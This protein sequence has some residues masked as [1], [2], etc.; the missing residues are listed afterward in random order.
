MAEWQSIESAPKD[1]TRFLA[2]VPGDDLDLP[3]IG[4]ACWDPGSPT[5][6]FTETGDPNLWRRQVI[7]KGHFAMD[8]GWYNPTHWAPLPDPPEAAPLT[9]PT[10]SCQICNSLQ[11]MVDSLNVELAR[12]KDAPAS[13]EKDIWMLIEARD[14]ALVQLAQSREV[15]RQLEWALQACIQDIRE[16]C[17]DHTLNCKVLADDALKLYAA[18]RPAEES[19]MPGRCCEG[20]NFGEPHEC[21]K[22]K[23]EAERD[24]KGAG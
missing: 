11:K 5:I 8:G 3:V 22:S 10:Y 12:T 24:A 14:T 19:D 17:S 21:R 23:P 1:G 4:V 9:G 18:H 6:R 7:E 20:G 16:C 2:F 13:A 15:A